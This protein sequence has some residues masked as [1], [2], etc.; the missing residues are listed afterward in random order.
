MVL[1]NAWLLRAKAKQTYVKRQEIIQDLHEWLFY[2]GYNDS[3]ND[4][5]KSL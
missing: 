5:D 4:E 1:L 3:F 2:M